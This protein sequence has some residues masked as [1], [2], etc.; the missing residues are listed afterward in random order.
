ME[1]REDRECSLKPMVNF[2]KVRSVTRPLNETNMTNQAMAMMSCNLDNNLNLQSSNC[3]NPNIQLTGN[4]A[5]YF[6]GQSAWGYWQDQYYPQ[7]IRESYPVYIQDRAKD[8]GKQAFEIIK[9]MQDKKLMKLDTV[10]DFI[11][12]MDC[13][14]KIL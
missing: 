7:I 12:A 14:I 10:K 8:V 1:V 5:A 11:E 3:S 2:N 4:T 9:A 13:L 6:N